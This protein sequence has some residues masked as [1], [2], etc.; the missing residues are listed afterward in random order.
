MTRQ[1]EYSQ[2]T[3]NPEQTKH[4]DVI[5]LVEQDFELFVLQDKTDVVRQ[6][7]NKVDE[8]QRAF[9]EDD[10]IRRT[11]EAHGKLKSK[12]DDAHNLNCLCDRILVLNDTRVVHWRVQNVGMCEMVD[13]VHVELFDS[14]ETKGQRGEEHK[15]DRYET[16]GLCDVRGLRILH[17]VPDASS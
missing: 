8:I 15:E 17:H 3:E 10:A 7:R 11:P 13:D 5:R 1:L 6:Y 9:H 2:D 4:P 16:D 12:P 14:A